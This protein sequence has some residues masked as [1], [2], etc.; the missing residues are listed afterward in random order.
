[1]GEK[2][3]E[4]SSANERLKTFYN[5]DRMPAYSKGVF[6]ALNSRPFIQFLENMSGIKGLI[7]TIRVVAS[8]LRKQPGFWGSMRTSTT[9]RS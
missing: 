3:P 6:H 5:P 7:P 8:T 1:M 2:A 4:N 9:I